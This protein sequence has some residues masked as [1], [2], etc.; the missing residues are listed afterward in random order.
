M[1]KNFNKLIKA[2]VLGLA[3]LPVFAFAQEEVLVSPA[4]EMVIKLAEYIS[5]LAFLAGTILFGI[6]V[7]KF[8]KSTL[9]AIFTHMALGTAV[10]IF[11]SVF[12]QV[13]PESFSVTDQ[14]FEIMWHIMFYVG[15]LLYFVALKSLVNLGSA[16]VSAGQMASASGSK[17]WA[18]VGALVIAAIFFVP[19]MVEVLISGYAH[20]SLS[21][22]GIHHFISFAIAA[23]VTSY[24]IS[25][26]K[27]MGQIG[28]AIANPMILVVGALSLQHFWE[29][30]TESWGVLTVPGV[31]IE[32]VEQVFLV[33]AGVAV[34]IAAM[35]L[36][37]FVKSI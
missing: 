2:S 11:I 35:R 33:I 24:L 7:K 4:V 9:G 20:S 28:L 21:D 1:K 27:K 16:D 13:G 23:F 14:S 26:K 25:A 31:I 10:F 19:K 36:R 29:L 12:I 30:L 3:I 32:G 8:G 5:V 22:M 37:S 18:I 6:A 15:A 17:K 34:T